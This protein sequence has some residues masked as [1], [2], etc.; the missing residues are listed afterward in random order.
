M[1]TTNV[2]KH[3]SEEEKRKIFLRLFEQIYYKK[4]VDVYEKTDS[5]LLSAKRRQKGQH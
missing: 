2:F 5:N 1:T 4:E 3:V